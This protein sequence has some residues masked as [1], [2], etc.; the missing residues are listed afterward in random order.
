MFRKGEGLGPIDGFPSGAGSGV[1][2]VPTTLLIKSCPLLP[3]PGS[4]PLRG[5]GSLP[6]VAGGQGSPDGPSESGGWRREGGCSHSCGGE[7][8]VG[9][10]AAGVSGS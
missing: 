6:R 7:E 3:L 2:V 4:V 9:L 10:R 8:W 1:W 5:L